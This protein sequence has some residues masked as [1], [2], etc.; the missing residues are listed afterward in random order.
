MFWSEVVL[1]PLSSA[2]STSQTTY[3]EDNEA[4]F[5][6]WLPYCYSTCRWH[7]ETPCGECVGRASCRFAKHIAE[8]CKQKV[9]STRHDPEAH[10]LWIVWLLIQQFVIPEV[11]FCTLNSGWLDASAIVWSYISHKAKHIVIITPI[12]NTS[13]HAH[14]DQLSICSKRTC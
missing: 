8:W 2:M 6:L 11:L 4:C 13:A 7:H 5:L 10:F 12:N 14:A 9:E 3:E 1:V